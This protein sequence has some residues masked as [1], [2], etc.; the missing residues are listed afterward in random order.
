MYMRK[1]F[2]TVMVIFVLSFC[3]SCKKDYE[4]ELAGAASKYIQG[5]RSSV[6]DMESSLLHY[7]S[8]NNF[9]PTGL[10][11]S[12]RCLYYRNDGVVDI[13]HPWSLKI[14][15]DGNEDILLIDMNEEYAAFCNGMDL[16]LYNRNGDLLKK[17]VLGDD[18]NNVMAVMVMGNN[19]LYY[20]G[21]RLYAYD[22]Q[23]CLLYTS[24]SPRD[25]EESRMP[26]SA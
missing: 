26:A 2:F 5:D 15:L 25:V 1:V 17:E 14:Y 23:G 13:V 24:P 16:Y 9:D 12:T 21:K 20:L 6:S 7:S 18:S 10:K 19:V 22:I 11:S 3:V 8:G 4:A